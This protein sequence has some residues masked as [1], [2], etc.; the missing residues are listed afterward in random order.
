MAGRNSLQVSGSHV[1]SRAN[2]QGGKASL[3]KNFSNMIGE[4]GQS[5]L[6]K[7]TE[8][9]PRLNSDVPTKDECYD[10]ASNKPV[11]APSQISEDMWGELPKYQYIK[12]LEQQK[13]E[14]DDQAKKRLMVR[15]TLQKQL[16]EQE[17]EQRQLRENAK[18]M[19]AMI[20]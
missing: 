13:K 15:E 6:V 14:K 17:S 3:N 2:L 5:D 7:Q 16:R 10:D 11:E 12:Y 4:Q 1:A 19:D 20:L 9:V 18:K 8:S